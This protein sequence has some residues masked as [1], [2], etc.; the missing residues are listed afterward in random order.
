MD[1]RSPEGGVVSAPTRIEPDSRRF[2]ADADINRA[3][4][5]IN[6]ATELE[7]Q[8]RYTLGR[9]M[10]IDATRLFQRHLEFLQIDPE[11]RL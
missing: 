9:A 8:G 5:L 4:R 6:K 7:E 10:R 11:A 1:A 2:A 3:K